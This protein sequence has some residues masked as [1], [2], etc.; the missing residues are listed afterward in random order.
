MAYRGRKSYNKRNYSRRR[1][2]KRRYN[3][4]RNFTYGNVL[5]KVIGDVARLKGLIN[6]E[7]KTVDVS[8]TTAVTDSGLVLLLNATIAG[9]D[10]NNRDGRQIRFK[11]IQYAVNVIQD[12]TAVSTITRIMIVLDKQPNAILMVLTDLLTSAANNL[13]FRN[14][15]NRKRFVIL[16]DKI[17]TQ[18]DTANTVDRVQLYKQL[19][20]HTVYDDSNAGNITDI[21]TNALYMVI[22]SSEA[23]NAPTCQIETRARFIDN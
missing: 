6:T 10:F 1:G 7:F 9:D 16:S 20:F 19:D 21:E 22:I 15:D 11:S 12:P 8:N 5:D 3:N 23:T 14:L 18:S 13:D 2:G 17:V 4:N